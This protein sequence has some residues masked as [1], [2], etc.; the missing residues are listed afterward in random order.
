MIEIDV[1]ILAGQRD[2]PRDHQRLR[3]DM[4][5]FLPARNLVPQKQKR[6]PVTFQRTADGALSVVATRHL[7][8]ERLK[9]KPEPTAKRTAALLEKQACHSTNSLRAHGVDG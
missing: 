7:V 9:S 3:R 2:Q 5:H 1:Q 4:Q 6:R 8:S